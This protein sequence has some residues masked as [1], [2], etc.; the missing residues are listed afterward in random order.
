MVRL[1]GVVS[2]NPLGVIG[3]KRSRH[4]VANYVSMVVKFIVIRLFNL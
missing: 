1:S 2:A 4:R 3:C